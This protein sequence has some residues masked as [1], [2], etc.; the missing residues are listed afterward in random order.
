CPLLFH[1]MLSLLLLPLLLPV[2]LAFKDQGRGS[3][4]DLVGIVGGRDAK[5]G[6]WPWQVSLRF[7][8]YHSCGGSIIHPRWVLTAAHCFH[9]SKNPAFYGIEAGVLRLYTAREIIPVK[10]ILIHP[11]YTAKAHWGA[12]IALVEL[13]IPL[14]FSDSFKNVDLQAPKDEVQPG[15]KCWVTGWGR[16]R[17]GKALQRPYTLQEVEVPIVD[18][19]TCK[20]NYRLIKISI[21][22]DMICAGYDKGQKDSCQAGPGRPIVEV[23]GHRVKQL[24]EARS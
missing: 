22:N 21:L 16:T 8:G 14:L 3:A 23:T 5:P 7:S 11:K 15:T 18:R 19:R 24:L 13:G 6:Q 4:W 10:R 2:N 12:D 17:E 20:K 1:T 9:S